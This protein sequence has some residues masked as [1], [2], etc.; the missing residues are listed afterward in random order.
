[1][2]AF[3]SP[4]G[5]RIVLA[6]AVI[7]ASCATIAPREVGVQPTTFDAAQRERSRSALSSY[8]LSEA[9]R[10][11]LRLLELDD[12]AES[13]PLAT[14]RALHPIAVAAPSRP[15]VFAL[16]ELC[17][18]H[19]KM[20]SDRSSFLAASLYAERYLLQEFKEPLNVFDRRFR[21]AIDVHNRGLLRAGCADAAATFV[22]EPGEYELPVGTMKVEHGEE[23]TG[24]L[25]A[26]RELLPVDGFEPWGLGVRL[27][28]AGVGVPLI[29]AARGS[30][31][32]GIETD[33]PYQLFDEFPATITLLSNEELTGWDDEIGAELELHSGFGPGYLELGEHRVPLRSDRSV[34]LAHWLDRAELW[35]FAFA[36][37][38]NG[39]EAEDESRLL[40]SEPYRPGAIPVVFV[41][42]TA[43]SPGYWA[44]LYNTIQWDPALRRTTQCW[45]FQ[46]ASGPPVAYSAAGLREA[47][48]DTVAALDPEGK[49]TALRRMVL[50][51][52]SQGGLLVRMMMVRGEVSWLEE[53]LGEDLDD[54]PLTDEDRA[55]LERCLDFEPLDFVSSAV[56]LST[57]HRGSFQT[58]RWYSEL[59]AEFVSLPKDFL[60]AGL[61]VVTLGRL[62]GM[63][64]SIGDM[65]SVDSMTP[66]S[67]L[68][69]RLEAIPMSKRYA[70]HSIIPI[71]DA[72]PDDPEQ[73]AGAN[74][75]VVEYTSAHL[76]GVDSEVLVP[77][78]HSCQSHPR[79]IREVRRILIEA[80]TDSAAEPPATPW[81]SR[82]RR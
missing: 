26:K 17:Y 76:E 29:V 19:G 48:T 66:G 55:L 51:G 31:G 40:L 47:L 71:G 7:G 52:H 44:D 70:L 57:P 28:E 36:G 69:Q 1:M 67:P 58:K 22:I 18:L 73:L 37:F 34:A 56:F 82:P 68:L 33:Q 25:E 13:N 30:K 59:V 11:A 72:D 2:T 43:S 23:L 6:L 12:E 63:G 3:R 54:L 35:A 32:V 4:L 75:G 9:T 16:A 50:I 42:G 74:D 65:T 8:L 21:W 38:F 49:D 45:F 24:W 62:N 61:Q 53:V 79:T 14:V 39:T 81:D 20:T 10:E 15:T 64:N 60:H 27:R 77:G 5:H 78:G 41:H 46:Y 80:V